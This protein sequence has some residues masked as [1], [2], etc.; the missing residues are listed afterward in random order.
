MDKIKPSDRSLDRVAREYG[1]LAE[2]VIAAAKEQGVFVHDA[3]ELFALLA[4]LDLDVQ[5]PQEMYPVIVEMLLWI[6]SVD[7][8]QRRGQV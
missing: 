6:S 8:S 1:T 4:Q 3:P 7:E 2:H 5:I